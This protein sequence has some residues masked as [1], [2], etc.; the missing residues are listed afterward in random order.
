MEFPAQTG[1][2]AQWDSMNTA[3]LA[4]GSLFTVKRITN[5]EAVQRYCEDPNPAVQSTS[6]ANGGFSP[7][8]T[9][10]RDPETVQ[11]GAAE[12]DSHAG[13]AI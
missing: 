4:T 10:E 13:H 9:E 6:E 8:G 2:F 5:Q 7:C 3:T 1:N 12:E 11:G